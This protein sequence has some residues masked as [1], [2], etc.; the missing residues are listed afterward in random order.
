M[1]ELHMLCVKLQLKMSC[2]GGNFLVNS[3]LVDTNMDT[4]LLDTTQSQIVTMLNLKQRSL[5]APYQIKRSHAQNGRKR[6]LTA[7]CS[8]QTRIGNL[9]AHLI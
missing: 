3:V 6:K 9:D 5:Y 8:H 7:V 4:S 1:R 2:S